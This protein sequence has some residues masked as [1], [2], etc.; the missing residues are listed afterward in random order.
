MIVYKDYAVGSVDFSVGD[1]PAF[2]IEEAF[3]DTYDENICTYSD[4]E[5]RQVAEDYL[6]MFSL[7]DYAVQTT[8]NAYHFDMGHYSIDDSMIVT[9]PQTDGIPS[10]TP[11][12]FMPA[13][14]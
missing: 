2:P 5:A 7:T 14:V 6:K 8:L 1:L 10:L 4:T 9:E 3:L 11:I 13:A 12:W